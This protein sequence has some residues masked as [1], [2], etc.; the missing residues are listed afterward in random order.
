TENA[1]AL[2]AWAVGALLLTTPR[3]WTRAAQ[4][5]SRAGER[6]GPARGYELGLQ[7][8]NRL[9]TTLHDVE[10]RDLRSRVAAVLIPGGIL[11]ALGFVGTPTAGA[12]AGGRVTGTDL[13]VLAL[14]TLVAVAAVVV[15]TTREHVSIVLSLAVV[16]LGLATVYA[17]VGAPDVALVAVLVE[18]V[19]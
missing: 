8:L 11:V 18:T 10:V 6:A 5:P 19:V 3:L 2:A 14:L 9:S 15:T 4:V 1:M 13:L 17:L 16:G 7:G 12:F